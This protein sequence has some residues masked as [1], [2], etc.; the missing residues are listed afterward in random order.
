MRFL[1]NISEHMKVHV[2]EH[3]KIEV[4]GMVI[5]RIEVLR[6]VFKIQ[7]KRVCVDW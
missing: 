7:K 1:R 4:S 5:I 2:S 3:H 6:A